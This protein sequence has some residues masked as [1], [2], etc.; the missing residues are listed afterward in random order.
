MVMIGHLSASRPVLIVGSSFLLLFLLH[1]QIAEAYMILHP[2][3]KHASPQTWKT[4]SCL[5]GIRCEDKFYQLEERE[6]AETSSTEVYLMK[7]RQVDFGM[8]DGPLPDSVEGSWQVEPGTDNFK[9][10]IRR[11][12]GSGKRG[13]DMGEFQFEIVRELRGEMTMVGDSV[14]ITG[15]VVNKDELLGDKGTHIFQYEYQVALYF[16]VSQTR[17]LKNF[18]EVGYFNMVSSINDSRRGLR[19]RLSN[20]E[21]CRLTTRKKERVIPSTMDASNSKL[22]RPKDCDLVRCTFRK[23]HLT[24]EECLLL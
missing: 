13:S 22:T 9:M 11:V 5:C 24:F 1:R 15:T 14:A 17:L 21:S 4:A 18:V 2:Q 3:R 23:Q 8:S 10:T 12:F 20:N 6:D 7:D 16:S 19:Q